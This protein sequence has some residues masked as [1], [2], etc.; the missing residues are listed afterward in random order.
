MADLVVLSTEAILM[1]CRILLFIPHCFVTLEVLSVVIY[2]YT[3]YRTWEVWLYNTTC[4]FSALRVQC[5]W[6]TVTVRLGL[7]S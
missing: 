1:Y 6:F 3:L 2:M 7:L 5:V 4:F